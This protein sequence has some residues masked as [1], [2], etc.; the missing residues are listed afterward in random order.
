MTSIS[1]IHVQQLRTKEYFV[2]CVATNQE[3][4]RAQYMLDKMG[5]GDSFDK[6]YVSAYLGVQKPDV[7]FFE[8]VQ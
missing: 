4:Y 1:S 7:T 5:F 6:I 3:K 8:K 2:C